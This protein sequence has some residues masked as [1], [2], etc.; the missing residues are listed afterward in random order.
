MTGDDGAERLDEHIKNGYQLVTMESFVDLTEAEKDRLARLKNLAA[1]NV[2]G[3][4]TLYKEFMKGNLLSDNFAVTSN[5]MVDLLLDE[6]G[7]ATFAVGGQG[8]AMIERAGMHAR[9]VLSLMGG[10]GE[11]LVA[12]AAERLR[13]DPRFQAMNQTRQALVLELGYALATAREGGRLTDQDVDRAINSLGLENPDPR[14]V[15]FTFG[16]A[17]LAKREQVARSLNLSGVQDIDQ[18][19]EAHELTL[20][21]YDKTIS[22]LRSQ[23]DIDFSDES[24]FANRLSTKS[25]RDSADDIFEVNDEGETTV[26]VV[27]DGP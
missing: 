23:Y 2:A 17:L 9:S 13:G 1:T 26:V 18:A 10:E 25:R 19:R 4:S 21:E 27:P 14:S 8:K 12:S 6:Q 3:R 22:R 5:R 20:A 7:M 11:D 15:A 24:E 16:N